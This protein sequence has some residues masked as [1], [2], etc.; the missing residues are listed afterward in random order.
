[1]KA[2]S[3]KYPMISAR[4]ETAMRFSRINYDVRLLITIIYG[5]YIGIKKRGFGSSVEFLFLVFMTTKFDLPAERTEQV[6]YR[7]PRSHT[8]DLKLLQAV[9]SHPIFTKPQLS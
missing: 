2:K 3:E 4:G 1:M 6:N 7:K 8:D 9:A 5:D